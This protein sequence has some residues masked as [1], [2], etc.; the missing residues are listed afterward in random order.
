M[1]RRV[2]PVQFRDSLDHK[3]RRDVTDESRHI[4]FRRS[5]GNARGA[6]TPLDSL[7]RAVFPP[8]RPDPDGRHPTRRLGHS[9]LQA[10]GI[11]GHSAHGHSLLNDVDR[12]DV[13]ELPHAACPRRPR[14]SSV[15]REIR[16]TF[17]IGHVSACQNGPLTCALDHKTHRSG[18]RRRTSARPPTG[19]GRAPGPVL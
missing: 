2:V 1:S 16:R 15:L 5:A 7:F 18:K 4:A 13:A 17:G 19:R 14:R 12:Y 9:R 8:S 11:H 10:C 6:R 3:K